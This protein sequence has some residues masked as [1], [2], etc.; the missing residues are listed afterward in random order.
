MDFLDAAVID[1]IELAKNWKIKGC[2]FW[3]DIYIYACVYIW[4]YIE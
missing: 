4:Q 1:T 2:T 3:Y